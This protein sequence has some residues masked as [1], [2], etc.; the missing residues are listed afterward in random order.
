[1]P[2]PAFPRGGRSGASRLRDAAA[3]VSYG[4][5]YWLGDAAKEA[6]CSSLPVTPAFRPLRQKQRALSRWARLLAKTFPSLTTP[7]ALTL[8]APG[9][10]P[11]RGR[12]AP[13]SEEHDP[14][15]GEEGLGSAA[16]DAVAR[17]AA[18]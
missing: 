10:A 9:N 11:A 16:Q 15:A 12:G 4:E 7:G 5:E 13:Y 8:A 18:D 6:Q 2:S 1:M 3:F 14:R 17:G